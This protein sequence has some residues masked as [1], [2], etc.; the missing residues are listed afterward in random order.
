[1]AV[2]LVRWFLSLPFMQDFLATY[3]GEYHLPE[4]RPS[5]SRRGSAG[6]T[7]STCS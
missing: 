4:G 2:V 6:S 1:M 7:S 3:P 5:A